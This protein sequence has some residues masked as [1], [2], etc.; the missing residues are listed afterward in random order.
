MFV[1]FLFAVGYLWTGFLL[2]CAVLSTHNYELGK[3]VVAV[4]LTVVGMIIIVF[5]SLL[6]V[7][8]ISQM[9]SMVSN[10]YNEITFRM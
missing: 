9:I 4:A 3:N 6:F 1:N 10:I 5:L 8:L 2:F 7:N